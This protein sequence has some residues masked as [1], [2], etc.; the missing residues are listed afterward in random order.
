[1]YCPYCGTQLSDGVNY[2]PNCGAPVAAATITSITANRADGDY[3]LILLNRGT[4]TKTQTVELLED[5]LGYSTSLATQLYAG[6]PIEIAEGLTETQARYLAQAFAEYGVQV[7]IYDQYDEYVDLQ[8]ASDTSIFNS[9]GSLIAAALAVLTGISAVNRV[10]SFRRYK[11]P[12]LLE[13]IFRLAFTP[14][15]KP[16]HVRRSIYRPA[17]QPAKKPARLQP[18][19]IIK[20]PERKTSSRPSAQPRKPS[21][22][23]GPR[24]GKR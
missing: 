8:A 7:S 24:R 19:Q 11:K 9:D 18:V 15:K 2:C 5:L 21:G 23:N 12:G 17:P 1:M 14:K 22:S 13:R 4:C 10:N 3:R 20:K 16:V 6:M